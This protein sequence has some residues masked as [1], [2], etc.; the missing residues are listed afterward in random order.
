MAVINA[1]HIIP[2]GHYTWCGNRQKQIRM[3]IKNEQIS[4]VNYCFRLQHGLW[5]DRW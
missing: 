1:V 2:N 4:H 5:Y 3:M